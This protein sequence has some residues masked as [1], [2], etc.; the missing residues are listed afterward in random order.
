MFVR[1]KHFPLG[2]SYVQ[3]EHF[4]RVVRV[5]PRS[6]TPWPRCTRLLDH[7]KAPDHK[8]CYRPAFHGL[9]IFGSWEAKPRPK[10]KSQHFK[11]TSYN[12]T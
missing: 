6:I 11:E 2:S 3:L 8:P 10:H 9:I 1:V 12:V 4:F 5:V 7:P